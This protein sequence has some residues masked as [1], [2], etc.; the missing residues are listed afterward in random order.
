MKLCIMHFASS[1]LRIFF[2]KNY[3]KYLCMEYYWFY[4]AVIV[5]L[6][7]IR[8]ETKRFSSLE[9]ELELKQI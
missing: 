7:R 2:L 8:T 4:L 3:F 5:S 9:L 1:F 6:T